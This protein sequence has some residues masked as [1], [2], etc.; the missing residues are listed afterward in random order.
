MWRVSYGKMKDHLE[1]LLLLVDGV[2]RKLVS[3]GREMVV[4]SEVGGWALW[5][6]LG[7]LDLSLFLILNYMLCWFLFSFLLLSVYMALSY[8]F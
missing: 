6:S 5:T 2:A 8:N 1:A 7:K 3:R 4:A